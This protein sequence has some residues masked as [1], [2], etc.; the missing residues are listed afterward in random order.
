[1]QKHK[2]KKKKKDTVVRQLTFGKI[3]P[4][5][6]AEPKVIDV[7][8]KREML[9][10]NSVYGLKSM[11]DGPVKRLFRT[12]SLLLRVIDA[13]SFTCVIETAW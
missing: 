2:K 1:M 6:S 11:T 8:K 10:T 5:G 9:Y 7:R 4:H 12:L 13:I 3:I